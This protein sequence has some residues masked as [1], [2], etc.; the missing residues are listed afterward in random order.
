M[1]ESSITAKRSSGSTL[2]NVINLITALVVLI[3]LFIVDFIS[4][5]VSMAISTNFA[6]NT[7]NDNS[8]LRTWFW[9]FSTPVYHIT[10]SAA[11]V[12]IYY[13]REKHTAFKIFV[14][15][16]LHN[17]LAEIIRLL[18]R[19]TRPCFESDII[20]QHQC[21]CSYGKLSSTTS[22]VI[23]LLLMTYSE[24]I[25]K[26][27]IPNWAKR[28]L[29]TLFVFVILNTA[30]GRIYL[31]AHSINQVA[32][33][34][35]FGYVCFSV[36]LCFKDTLDDRFKD[37]L[38]SHPS[39]NLS[40]ASRFKLLLLAFSC[41]NNFFLLTVWSLDLSIFIHRSSLKIPQS[42]CGKTCIKELEHLSN[43]HLN[44]GSL[45][46]IVSFI[47][48]LLV[49]F[50][51][52]KGTTISQNYY[53]NSLAHCKIIIMRMLLFLLMSLPVLGAFL[54]GL[55]CD[56]LPNYLIVLL[57]ALFYSVTLVQKLPY[58]LRINK[59][60]V[61]GDIFTTSLPEIDSPRSPDLICV[62]GKVLNARTLTDQP[63][64]GRQLLAH[65]LS[66]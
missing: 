37:L 13:L 59:I 22:S 19:D 63:S 16:C 26:S 58:L 6:A 20:G 32:L 53:K 39:I 57:L 36:A 41:I 21:T 9:I 35:V 11:Y 29:L 49:L 8:F 10:Q 2:C 56:G 46:I 65:E 44:Q 24:I 55:F 12:F 1:S 45:S 48:I 30:F 40:L 15:V 28:I 47:M 33:G 51:R 14:G 50:P 25:K 5:D 38:N 31:G 18:F 54:T 62:T 23:L 7:V 66:I 64:T 42:Q 34:L 60:Q 43:T 3:G 61:P 27:D 52:K 17:V 4:A